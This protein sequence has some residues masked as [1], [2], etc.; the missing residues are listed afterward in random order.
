[1]NKLLACSTLLAI[2]VIAAAV[3]P[4]SADL[5]RDSAS[6][7]PASTLVYA[8][9]NGLHGVFE[10]GLRHPVIAR[11]L[12][13]PAGDLIEKQ[14]KMPP[15]L[16]LGMLN[17]WAGRTVLP[18][19][20]AMTQDG[21]AIG[22]SVEDDQPVFT[23]VAR[24]DAEEW[25]AVIDLALT[26]AAEQMQLPVD[27]IV[28]PHRQIR[29]VDVWLLGD[30]LAMGLQ[31]GVFLAAGNEATLRVMIDLGAAD[32]PET[33]GL[34]GVAGFQNARASEYSNDAFA[35]SWMDLDGLTAGKDSGGLADLR[36]MVSNPGMQLLLGPVISTLTTASEAVV[37]LGLTADG[38][39]L[40]MTGLNVEPG[41]ADA[42]LLAQ[43]ARP[44]RLP[45]ATQ[46]ETARAILYRDM[47]GIFR[48]RV[49]L[50]PVEV[51]PKFAEATAGL[52]LFFGGVDIVDEVLPGL[53]PW[54]G[55]VAREPEYAEGA[56]P[57]L[58]LPAAAFLV[59]L[60]DPEDMGDV[61]ISAFQNL[62]AI[63]NITGAQEMRPSMRLGMEVHEGRTIT[64]GTFRKP[65]EGEGVD[66]RYNLVPACTVV[67]DTFILGTHLSLVRELSGQLARG[68][69]EREPAA[70]ETFT[71][72]GARI[73]EVVAAN[74]ETLV[75]NA[76]LNDGKDEATATGEVDALTMIAE[77]IESLSIETFRPTAEDLRF[78]LRLTLAGE[79][80]K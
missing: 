69:L 2:P 73:A 4:T 33:A 19:L 58:P 36:G 13:S 67:G 23:L 40:K 72:R 78:R 30:K 57:E 22:V 20:A 47:D 29:G 51:Q 38:L 16:G 56:A 68:E 43:D 3:P 7:M 77:M 45:A 48:N 59:H 6:L 50:F 52:S 53:G 24:G 11:L 65:A 63:L 44:P 76:M 66:M 25:R 1:M 18:S 10:Q 80:G 21:V 55:I 41:A 62:L 70:G 31:G 71:L 79:E 8:E 17:M 37:E 5:Q 14:M 64:F 42:V 75:M 39:D 15:V 54:V 12:A 26:K 74:R 28:P 49:D 60:E 27:K 46:D 35:W 9:L 34:A 32:E 61:M